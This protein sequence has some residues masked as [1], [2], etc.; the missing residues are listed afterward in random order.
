MSVEGNDDVND[1]I[2]GGNMRRSTIV[3]NVDVGVDVMVYTLPD[4]N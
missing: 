1:S 4:G 2:Y 3:H